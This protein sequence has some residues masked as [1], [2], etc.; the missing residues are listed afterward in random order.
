MRI[1]R[2]IPEFLSSNSLEARQYLIDSTYHEL[3]RAIKHLGLEKNI[4]IDID[5]NQWI[6]FRHLKEALETTHYSKRGFCA[7]S[8]IL[9]A[10]HFPHFSK[11]MI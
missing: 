3:D 9:G 6:S 7:K 5:G 8:V 4:V 10:T 1:L 2:I 11:L